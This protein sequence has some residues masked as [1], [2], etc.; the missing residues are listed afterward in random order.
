MYLR[1]NIYLLFFILIGFSVPAYSLS[2]KEDPDISKIEARPEI[3]SGYHSEAK[4]EI[5]I[6]KN[7]SDVKAWFD[8]VAPEK[9]IRGTLKVSGI[10]KTRNFGPKKWGSKGSMRM[11]CNKDDNT[12][13]E[14]ILENNPGKNFKYELWD[15]TTDKTNA[16]KYALAEFQVIPVSEN[17][18]L[19]QWTVA[20]R[21]SMY[22]Y[23]IPLNHYVKNSFTEYME[24]GLVNIKK[25]LES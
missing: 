21:P 3:E 12:T 11:I 16:I 14:Q 7:P 10:A 15:F 13:L 20:F 25:L 9:V 2:C 17:K 4:V 22:L 6:N 5:E 18:S 19:L 8:N 24:A 23:R 1:Q